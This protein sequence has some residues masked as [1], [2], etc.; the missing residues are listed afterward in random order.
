MR[1]PPYRQEDQER[2][3][4]KVNE[5]VSS[6]LKGRE[7]QFKI[8]STLQVLNLVLCYSWPTVVHA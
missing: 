4:T 1:V 6:L 8:L 7:N 5:G 3:W 2:R